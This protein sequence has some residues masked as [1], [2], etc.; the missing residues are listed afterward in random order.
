MPATYSHYHFA[1]EVIN[2]LE[3]N[4]IKNIIINN[5]DTFNIGIHGPDIFFFYK[6]YKP[7]KINRYAKTIHHDLAINFFNEARSIIKNDSQLAYI[8]GFIC[9]YAFDHKEHPYISSI[10]KNTKVKHQEVESEFDRIYMI[11]DNLN[12]LTTPLTNHMK[13]NQSI[14]TNLQPF[15]KE[16][17]IKDI[18]DS[19]KSMKFFDK[20]FIA[21]NPIKRSILYLG[22]HCTFHFKTFQGLIMNYKPNKK[23]EP[24]YQEFF[25]RYDEAIILAINLLNNFFNNYKTNNPL[26]EDFKHN[27]Y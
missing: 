25:D 5:I 3:N 27:Y 18:N 9:H 26:S 24:Y 21:K 12:P 4:D 19:I 20:L 22:F 11:K 17:S 16:A 6:P 8:L 15:F 13:Y 23:I 2:K 10:I 14:A 7:C 1:K